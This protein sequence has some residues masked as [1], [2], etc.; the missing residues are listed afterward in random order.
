MGCIR[1]PQP[2]E[3]RRN[4][5]VDKLSSRLA[6]N[7]SVVAK[8]RQRDSMNLNKVGYWSLHCGANSQTMSVV[9]PVLYPKAHTG[10]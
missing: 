1:R 9:A 8:S 7:S 10:M 2:H 5:D 6:C 4:K 3:V